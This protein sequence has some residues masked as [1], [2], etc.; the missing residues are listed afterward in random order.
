MLLDT[1]KRTSLG[2]CVAH[3]DQSCSQK[4]IQFKL[5]LV[6][7][8]LIFKFL[9]LIWFWTRQWRWCTIIDLLGTGWTMKMVWRGLS[10][11][12]CFDFDGDGLVGFIFLFLRKHVSFTER[13]LANCRLKESNDVGNF[14]R[15]MMLSEHLAVWYRGLC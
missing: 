15:G 6:F 13:K 7:R 14:G 12:G 3:L 1:N 10:P 8:F 11:L 5:V 9:C 2:L 4:S